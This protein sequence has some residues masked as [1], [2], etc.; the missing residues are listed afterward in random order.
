[1]DASTCLTCK[2]D[3]L[4]KEKPIDTSSGNFT[5]EIASKTPYLCVC[6]PGFREINQASCDKVFEQSKEDALTIALLYLAS[7]TITFILIKLFAK[8]QIELNTLVTRPKILLQKASKDSLN[9]DE[10]KELTKSAEDHQDSV[11]IG[12]NLGIIT[13]ER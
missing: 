9:V 5:S 1:M 6:R 3:R 10:T 13:T 4:L 12:T 8:K 2:E 7:C 11:L